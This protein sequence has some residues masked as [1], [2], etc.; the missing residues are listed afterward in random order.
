MVSLSGAAHHQNNKHYQRRV[1]GESRQH[2]SKSNL[3]ENMRDNSNGSGVAIQGYIGK[4]NFV[5]VLQESG[6]K[7][8]DYHS[9][10]SNLARSLSHHS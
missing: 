10:R 9:S 8:K 4:Q 6:S 5:P 7:S 3:S 1:D 2:S